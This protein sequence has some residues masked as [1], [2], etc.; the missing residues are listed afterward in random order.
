MTTLADPTKLII[1]V[2]VTEPSCL[3]DPIDIFV[4][5]SVSIRSLSDKRNAMLALHHPVYLLL[6]LMYTLYLVQ[7]G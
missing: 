3:D 4:M 7:T 5:W 6:T 2:F 1:D